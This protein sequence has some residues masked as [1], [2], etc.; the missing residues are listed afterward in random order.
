MQRIN[1]SLIILFVTSLIGNAQSSNYNYRCKL[2]GIDSKWHKITLPNSI[3]SKLN[4]DLSDLRIYGINEENDTIE[5]PYILK[6]NTTRYET[7]SVYAEII[8]ETQVGRRYYYT[9]ENESYDMINTV[10]LNFFNDNFDWQVRLEGSNNAKNWYTILKNERILGI[11]KGSIDYQHTRLNF[12]TVNYQYL[13][14]SFR[15]DIE[16]ELN[17]I[18]IKQNTKERGILQVYTPKSLKISNNPENKTTVIDINLEETVPVSKISVE[19]KDKFDYYRPI[20]IQR[21][22]DSVETPDGWLPYYDDLTEKVLSSIDDN[23]YNFEYRFANT[24]QILIYNHDNEELTIG[25]VTVVGNEIHLL[26]R[27]NKPAEY[28][29]YYGKKNAQLP[30]YDITEFENSVPT[31]LNTLLLEKE[32]NLKDKTI[33]VTPGASKPYWLWAIMAIIIVIIGGFTIKML[34]D[35]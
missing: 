3:F 35:E 11:N 29:L 28:Y 12:S 7:K 8:N 6:E 34:K 30:Y 16:P 4:E 13:R 15:S 20:E 17:N 24:L 2:S 18:S 1:I 21:L 33:E 14:L 27:F 31:N 26:A 23:T 19:V 5:V 10:D 25:E 22:I 32:E 9:I